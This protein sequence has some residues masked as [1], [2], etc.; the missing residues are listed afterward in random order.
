MIEGTTHRDL[1]LGC[2]LGN[3]DLLTAVRH[4]AWLALPGQHVQPVDYRHLGAEELGSVY[5]SLLELRPTVDLAQRTLTLQ[6]LA[7]SERRTTGTYYTPPGLV[8]ALLD[9]AL[10][11]VLDDAVKNAVDRAD[12]EA[13]L[14]ALTVCDAAC[15]S[16]HFLVAAARRLAQ[17]LAQLRS[18]ED[19]PTPA[20][21]QHALR[22]VTGRC[23]YGVDVN[24]LAAEL[25][26]V[27]LWLEALEPGKPLGFLDARIRVGN[28]LLGTTPALLRAGVPDAAFMELEG[29]DKRIA[30][31]VRKR[32]KV[33]ADGQDVLL[34]GEES[35]VALAAERAGVLILAQDVDE[36]RNQAEQWEA[37]EESDGLPDAQDPR[38]RMVR[39]LRLAI[40]ARIP[41]TAHQRRAPRDR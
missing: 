6:N 7:G 11:P 33:Q 14:L 31:G 37:Y 32:N 29:D 28:S 20:D 13:R 1:L 15:G 38:R 24:D 16:G 22:D 2:A 19:E 35:N 5:E 25:A 26:K 39:C 23:L 8:S 27:S 4:L 34:F 10:D 18:G 17:R 36:V 41:G 21:V 40:A 30:A 3:A 12:A 9:S